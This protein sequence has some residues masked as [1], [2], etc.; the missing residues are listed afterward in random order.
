MWFLILYA[1]G[2]YHMV[3]CIMLR[4][5]CH[6]MILTAFFSK[7]AS[8]K[9]DL[10]KVHVYFLFEAIFFLWPSESRHKTWYSF[11]VVYLNV[12]VF[13]LQL[14]TNNFQNLCN[15]FFELMAF[16]IVNL[17]SLIVLLWNKFKSLYLLH[18]REFLRHLIRVHISSP[19]YGEILLSSV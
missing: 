18:L 12:M 7:F 1:C 19:L 3:I 14:L 4:S 2:L 10:T 5:W 11:W 17:D 9:I 16:F 13:W 6:I 15:H 8:F